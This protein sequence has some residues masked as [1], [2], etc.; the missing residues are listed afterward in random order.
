[1]TKYQRELRAI[2]KGRFPRF[3]II[4]KW[5]YQEPKNCRFH[6]EN[7]RAEGG[8]IPDAVDRLINENLFV[9][10]DFDTLSLAMAA[11]ND[12][13]GK[14]LRELRE[15]RPSNEDCIP[16]LGETIVKE[17]LIRLCARG[18]MAI[19]LRGM[20]VLQRQDG[21]SEDDAWRRMR[22]K[23][24][25][26]KHLDETHLLSPQNVPSTGGVTQPT[27]GGGLPPVPAPGDGT[28]PLAPAPGGGPGYRSETGGGPTP[29]IFD[30]TESFKS[31]SVPA[32]SS[33]NLLGKLENWRIGPGT[34]IRALSLKVDHLTGSQLRDMIRKLPDGVTYELNIEKEE[35]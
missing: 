30:G 13:V 7:H 21:E 4:C 28:A 19:N 24:G 33:L 3:A 17:R 31:F 9:P 6:I 35:S 26:G 20:E 25:T 29:S 8:H 18:K 22:G 2:L 27:P 15:P 1:M 10:E 16:W 11:N 5:N 12:T 23:L 32:T 14:L 34:R